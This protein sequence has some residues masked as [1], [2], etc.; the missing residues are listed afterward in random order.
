M[1]IYYCA[2]YKAY[3]VYVSFQLLMEKR[4]IACPESCEKCSSLYVCNSHAQDA[5]NNKRGLTCDKC[6]VKFRCWTEL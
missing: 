6:P 4:T 5:I 2:K 3:A 1:M